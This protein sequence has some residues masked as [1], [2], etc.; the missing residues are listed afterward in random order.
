MPYFLIGREAAFM[1]PDLRQAQV[2]EQKNQ[3]AGFLKILFIV[4]FFVLV[5]LLSQSMVQHRF[6][7]GER[8]HDNGSVGQ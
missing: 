1:E 2:A 3:L 4:V 6:F 8:V 7:E 5:L